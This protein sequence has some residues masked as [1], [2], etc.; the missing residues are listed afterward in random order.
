MAKKQARVR[1]FIW[2]H[3]FLLALVVMMVFVASLGF[4]AYNYVRITKR[5]DSSRQWDLPSRIY[6]DAMPIV[7]GL[8]YPRALLEP[9]LNHVGYVE[10]ARAL[11]NPGEYRYTSAGLEIYLQNFAY[12]DIDFRAMPVRIEFDH[13]QVKRIVRLPDE[14][15]L[16]AVRL[17]PELVTSIYDEVMEDRVP[18]PLDSVPKW[19][20]EAIVAAEDK[21]FY[22]H[23]G[24]SIRGILRAAY[25]NLRYGEVR[26]GGSTI[27]QQLVKNLFLTPDRNFGRKAKEA[28][29]AILLETRYSK[30]D[31]LEA[32]L[33]EVY[34]GQN[35]SVQ[36]KGVEEA[37]RVYFSKPARYLTLPEAATLAAIIPSPNYYSP[38]NHPERA[39]NRRNLVLRLMLEQKKITEEQ[40]AAAIKAPMTL[41]RYP[42]ELRSAPYFVDLVMKQLRET[43]P[44]TQLKTEGLRIFTTLDTVMQR[45]A[46]KAL[47]R[48]VAS[49]AKTYSRIRK[50]PT[51]LEGV[52]IT[53]QPGTGYVK[54]LVGGRTYSR[55]QFNR[56][57]QAKR[58]PGS[59]FKPF[60]YVAAMDPARGR[61][62]LTVS[63][64][65][66]DSPIAVQTGSG[67]WRPQNY[68]NRYHG[69]PSVRQ[70]LANSYNVPA[71]R[72]AIDAG[73][74]NV[75]KLA[76]QIGV[77]SRLE[78]Y[79]S[80]S[81]GAFEVTPLE[82]AYAYSVFA[83]EGVKAEPISIL[84]VA[85]REGKVLE[86]REVHMK[87]VIS[88]SLT[89]VVNN[90]LQDVLNYGTA[91]K[92]RQLGFDRN[93]AG[94]TGTTNDYRDAWFIGYSARI[95]T[96]VWV[97]FDDNHS[98]GL[99]GGAA[100]VPIWADYMNRVIDTVPQTDFR[101]PD[102]I[103]ERQIDP[104]SGQLAT[105]ACPTSESEIYVRGTEPE[106]SCQLHSYGTEPFFPFMNGGR[107]QPQAR[108]GAGDPGS[109]QQ[110]T[111]REE[112]KKKKKKRPRLFRWLFGDQ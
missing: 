106:E 35:G 45:A 86:S 66:D 41:N 6:S 75:I 84:A 17:E 74:P 12:P 53:I 77:S 28:L 56:A 51:P 102:D 15:S 72:A 104:E 108:A 25:T 58:Q 107:E 32:Y 64:R 59:L 34:L 92:V 26:A 8:R 87:R 24:V 7:P 20:S 13:S 110:Q 39:E 73:V 57:L 30:N 69:T 4:V 70:A 94:K 83:N 90:I 80:V 40:Y 49:L 3:S 11:E 91:A 109:E 99:S 2:R 54:A 48:G 85:T 19:L 103:V 100:A 111:A 81:L 105:S 44:E 37:S 42:R 71:V 23:E 62:A 52:V 5:F 96:L 43:Y 67:V 97:G 95:L 101:R 9:K 55:S 68:D 78:P 65:L 29:M 47:E 88:A 112:E 10:V 50:S 36:M 93:F 60:V 31:I 46:E 61:E 18:I 16:R 33:N 89:Y 22:H 82:I 63:S 14:I 79:P 38:L 1:G 76:A 98:V 27:T 21:G